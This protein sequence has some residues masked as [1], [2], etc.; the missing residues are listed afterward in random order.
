MPG[1]SAAAYCKKANIDCHVFLPETIPDEYLKE[2]V[3]IN[4]EVYCETQ[5]L[6]RFHQ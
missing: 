1:I 3:I 5:M 6:K 4:Q 2:T